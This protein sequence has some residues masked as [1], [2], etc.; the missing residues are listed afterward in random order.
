VLAHAVLNLLAAA[1][2]DSPGSQLALHQLG[3]TARLLQLLRTP[4]NS[5]ALGL[6]T[7]H[8]LALLANKSLPSAQA[9]ATTGG[10]VAVVMNVLQQQAMAGVLVS[11]V[12]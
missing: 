5:P 1:L 10:L 7:I 6:S 4:N 11:E 2:S 9:E 8:V 12:R 3:A